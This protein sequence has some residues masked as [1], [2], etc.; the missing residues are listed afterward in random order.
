MKQNLKAKRDL[1]FVTVALF[2]AL[3]V[4]GCGGSNGP[5]GGGFGSVGPANAGAATPLTASGNGA[6]MT[7]QATA[8]PKTPE[9]R[10]GK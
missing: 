8:S 5:V 7:K 2:I 3:I 4:G 9:I 6:T 1:L 10:S